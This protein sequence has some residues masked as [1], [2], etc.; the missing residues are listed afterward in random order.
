MR[1]EQLA[2]D[3]GGDGEWWAR[4]HPERT[5]RETQCLSGDLEHADRLSGEPCPHSRSADG[6]RFDRQYPCPRRDEV[7]GQRPVPGSDIQYEVTGSDTGVSD[8]ARGP[9]VDE[10]V[11]S[12]GPP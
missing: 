10:R 12:P 7:T 6:V 3:G 9:R 11:P 5:G 1:G 8:D 2:H 4:H